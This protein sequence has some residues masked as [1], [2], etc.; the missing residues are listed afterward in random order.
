[1]EESFQ[2]RTR[3]R[4]GEM[5]GGAGEVLRAPSRA[6]I[7]IHRGLEVCEGSWMIY[8]GHAHSISWIWMRSWSWSWSWFRWCGVVW[9]GRA[10]R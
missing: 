1:M 3:A 7:N 6:Y 2:N 5:G 4:R 8:V 10:Q 9:C